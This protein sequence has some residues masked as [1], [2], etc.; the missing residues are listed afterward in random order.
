MVSFENDYAEGAHPLV[1]DALLRTNLEQLPG[2][3]ADPY[4]AR[5][6]RKLRSACGL[7][8]AGVF[9]LSGG[10]QTNRIVISA[11]LRPWEGV[12]AA[13]TGHVAVH[14][15][16]AIEASGHKVL[17]VPG[18]RGKLP[19]PALRDYL[20][21]F[22]ADGN[23]EHMVFP[24]MVYISWPT[25]YGTLYTKAELEALG[26]VCREYELPMYIDGAR[27]AYGLASPEADLTLPELASLCDVFYFGGTK[28]GALLGEALVFPRGA[29]AHFMTTVK[30]NGGLLAKGR[31]LGAQFDALFT[32]RLWLRIAKNAIDRAEELKTLLRRKGYTL[33]LES[34]T[35]QQFVLLEDAKA[36]ALAEQVAYSFW[37]KPDETHTVIRLA[38]SW[39]TTAE[40]LA[41]LETIL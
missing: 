19:A 3:G 36:A 40:Q 32:D 1:L 15:A 5:A 23:R 30:Q 28:C 2:Y 22:F 14:E 7:T 29:P 10:T 25:E 6:V 18:E 21:R 26:A 41:A 12:V 16:G 35:N 39:A 20:A 34:P 4:C 38:T 9:F 33:Y 13:E 24:G 31:V 27:M 37:E 11:L 8:E 17:T